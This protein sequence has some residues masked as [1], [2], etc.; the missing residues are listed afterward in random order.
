MSFEEQ[1]RALFDLLFDNELREKFCHDTN[2]ALAH[3][4]LDPDEL[5]DFSVIRP[6]ALA[7]DAQMRASLVLS[8]LGRSFPITFSIASSIKS[9]IDILRGL[10]DT[11]SMRTPPIER[12]TNFGTRLRERLVANTFDTPNEKELIIAILEAEL[13]MAW[14]STT[15]KR[16][17]LES[18]VEPEGI[19]MIKQDWSTQP[20]KL[21]AYVSA[22]KIPLPYEQLK[23]SLCPVTDSELWRHLGRSPTPAS[24]VSATL[25][26]EDPRLLVARAHVEHMSRCEPTVSHQTTE[27]SEGF[28]P[29]F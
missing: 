15:L 17:V 27:L 13:G 21:A 4:E 20:I 25:R 14:T 2:T 10:V 7:L 16:V 28:V 29:L 3:Y 5:N 22:A 19:A 23:S 11:Q 9:G 24:R 8:Q 6:D 26:K 18:G 12:A 1:E